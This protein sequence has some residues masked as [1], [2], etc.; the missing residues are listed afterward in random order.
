MST[1]SN[2][3][4]QR[5]T[6]ALKGAAWML[7]VFASALVPKGVSGAIDFTTIRTKNICVANA[8]NEYQCGPYADPACTCPSG[9]CC[10]R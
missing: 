9:L 8:T 7:G 5:M 2:D 6:I 3:F 10:S 4:L 1:Q